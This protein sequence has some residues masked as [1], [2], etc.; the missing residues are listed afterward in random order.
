MVAVQSIVIATW[1]VARPEGTLPDQRTIAGTLIP[2]SR[3]S[4]FCPV[5]GQLLEKQSPPL[6]LVTLTKVSRS[7]LASPS[8]LIACPIPSSR[9]FIIAAYVFS[10]P[11]ALNPAT[12]S[13]LSPMCPSPGPSQGQ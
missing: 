11:P 6:S 7:S 10:D 4:P 9:L 5:K 8:A 13:G 3:N 1:S 2:P 12:P